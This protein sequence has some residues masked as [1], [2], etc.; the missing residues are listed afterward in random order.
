MNEL[1]SLVN[2]KENL[3]HAFEN[4]IQASSNHNLKLNFHV[5]ISDKDVS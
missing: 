5:E 4:I 1:N 2:V 3:L